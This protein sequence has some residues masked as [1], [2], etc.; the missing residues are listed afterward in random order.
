MKDYDIR[1]SAQKGMI[2]KEILREQGKEARLRMTKRGENLL[3]KKIK[4]LKQKY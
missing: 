3:R 1:F 4:H 2:R